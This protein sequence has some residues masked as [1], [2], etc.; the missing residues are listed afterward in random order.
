M[1]LKSRARFA[2][3]DETAFGPAKGVAMAAQAASAVANS[4]AQKASLAAWSQV[5]SRPLDV[6]ELRVDDG[7][8]PPTHG[9]AERAR[10]P[11]SCALPLMRLV[12]PESVVGN[13]S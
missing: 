5:C 13:G 11:R 2:E 10:A 4:A 12:G 9:A 8:T 3:S 1:E 6:L 7:A